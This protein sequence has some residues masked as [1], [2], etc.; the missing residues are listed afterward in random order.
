M[1]PRLWLTAGR[2]FNKSAKKKPS[3]KQLEKD[4]VETALATTAAD[5]SDVWRRCILVPIDVTFY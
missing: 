4:E 5:A 2:N 3:E 1:W